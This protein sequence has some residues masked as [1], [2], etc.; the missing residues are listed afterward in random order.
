[1]T[2]T[3]KNPATRTLLDVVGKVKAGVI[4]HPSQFDGRDL[5][6]QAC[7]ANPARPDF[8]TSHLDEYENKLKRGGSLLGTELKHL[9][10]VYQELYSYTDDG[11]F[12]EKTEKYAENK[13][14]RVGD[15]ILVSN[16]LRD[17]AQVVGGNAKEEFLTC[18]I[19]LATRANSAAKDSL[20][21]HG[22]SPSSLPKEIEKELAKI[23][24]KTKGLSL[25][26]AYKKFEVEAAGSVQE[27]LSSLVATN[28]SKAFGM[29]ARLL[30]R[31]VLEN[32]GETLKATLV[33]NWVEPRRNENS[34]SAK[35]EG[36]AFTFGGGKS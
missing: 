25:I 23:P 1:M 8:L 6:P 15:W 16:H 2:E 30:Q 3:S 14:T 7:I 4:E 12:E 18:A 32:Q 34:I 17:R 10:D 36:V 9:S 31:D 20:C 5:N 13:L 35:P 24:S 19:E 22:C 28:P 26:E 21:R 33:H 27:S 11:F 29:L